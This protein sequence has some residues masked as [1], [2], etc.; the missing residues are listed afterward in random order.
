MPPKKILLDT[1]ET[2]VEATQRKE[3]KKGK[4]KREGISFRQ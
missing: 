3:G 1:M 2:P 4:G